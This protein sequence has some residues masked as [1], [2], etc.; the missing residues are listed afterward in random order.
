MDGMEW[1]RVGKNAVGGSYLTHMTKILYPL[2]ARVVDSC[3]K[4]AANLSRPRPLLVVHSGKTTIGRSALRLMS[5]SDDTVLAVGKKGGASPV[6][7][8]I[9]N[10]ET[11]LKP[12]MRERAVGARTGGEEIAADPVPVRRPGVRVTGLE[13]EDSIAGEYRGSHAG[14][15]NMGS[16]R[17]ANHRISI[18]DTQLETIISPG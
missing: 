9:D 14:N 13:V 2:T 6:A 17:N 15:T 16:N 4:T 8:S 7:W 10:R 12:R 18:Q 5:S 1:L 3:W 11:G